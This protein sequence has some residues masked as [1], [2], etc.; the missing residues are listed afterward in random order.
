MYV[1]KLYNGIAYTYIRF[2]G[3]MC[4]FHF[5]KYFIWSKTSFPTPG[6]SWLFNTCATSHAADAAQEL[7]ISRDLDVFSGRG[8]WTTISD[9]FRMLVSYSTGHWV[10]LAVPLD[11]QFDLSCGLLQLIGEAYMRLVFP[12]EVQPKYQVLEAA[13]AKQVDDPRIQSA[14]SPIMERQR[15]CPVCVDRFA[16]TWCL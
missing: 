4:L 14:C 9:S 13:S 12:F 6:G 16:S 11:E 15:S 7:A 8:G 3:A 1:Y 5:S 2:R 10:G